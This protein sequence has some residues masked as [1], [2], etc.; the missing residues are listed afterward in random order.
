M[1]VFIEPIYSDLF[2]SK[3]KLVK[4]NAITRIMALDKSVSPKK[5]NNDINEIE[6]DYL[7]QIKNLKLDGTNI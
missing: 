3:M 4:D 7:Q 2:L 5:L 1:D 6:E